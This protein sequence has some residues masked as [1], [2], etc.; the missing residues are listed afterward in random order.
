MTNAATL[1]EVFVRGDSNGYHI[2]VSPN[3]GYM[4]MPPDREQ[5]LLTPFTAFKRHWA[6]DDYFYTMFIPETNPDDDPVLSVLAKSL[7]SIEEVLPQ[8]QRSRPVYRLERHA[9]DDWQCLE[10]FLRR[11]ESCFA[12]W[13]GHLMPL[14][15]RHPR[16]PSSYGYANEFATRQAARKAVSM[17]RAAFIP[18]AALVSFHI[19]RLEDVIPARRAHAWDRGMPEDGF[20]TPAVVGLLRSS[21]MADFGRRRVGGFI[22]LTQPQP[23]WL[24]DL[25][26]VVKVAGGCV[27]LYYYLGRDPL[28]LPINSLASMLYDITRSRIE[29]MLAGEKRRC[30]EHAQRMES[31]RQQPAEESLRGWAAEALPAEQ[32]FFGWSSLPP[33]KPRIVIDPAAPEPRPGTRQLRGEDIF[34]FLMREQEHAQRCMAT[35][36]ASARRKRLQREEEEKARPYPTRRGPTVYHWLKVLGF[37]LRV[38]VPPSRCQAL[39]RDTLECHRIFNS[40]RNEWDVSERLCVPD[41]VDVDESYEGWDMKTPDLADDDDDELEDDDYGMIVDTSPVPGA[42]LSRTIAAVHGRARST[43]PRAHEASR[44][45]AAGRSE[46]SPERRA[47]DSIVA[48]ATA[49]VRR[50][51]DQDPGTDVSLQMDG[52]IEVLAARYGLQVSVSYVASLRD[53]DRLTKNYKNALRVL[54]QLSHD[55]TFDAPELPTILDFVD[56]MTLDNDSGEENAVRLLSDLT[57]ANARHNWLRHVS[58]LTVQRVT[59]SE[60]DKPCYVRYV[61]LPQ[62]SDRSW[63]L[64]VE[65]ATT[66]LEVVR[67]Q[68]GPSKEDAARELIKRE[69]P[70]R[71][72]TAAVLP[73]SSDVVAVTSPKHGSAGLGYR[74]P[75]YKPS[76]VDYMVYERQ[77]REILRRPHARVALSKGGIVWRLACEEVDP[78]RVLL[79]PQDSGPK[80]RE[81]LGGEAYED[82]AL[83]DEEIYTICGVYRVW[84]G[85]SI[86]NAPFHAHS[87]DSVP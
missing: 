83:S 27:P 44:S 16:L 25:D 48:L 29:A 72:L 52:L 17:A 33:P 50:D 36:S 4:S 39:W 57:P 56:S 49:L 8:G 11:L 77:R 74:E 53:K 45:T 7:S 1:P 61:L 19:M 46:S 54:F 67:R 68:W 71:T 31:G 6:N 5:P 13:G 79:G 9:A 18:W 43:S 42:V 41:G 35:E 23:R 3:D 47:E 82:D 28:A 58:T 60:G 2:Y 63:K 12:A 84:Q 30:L 37:W 86:L 76:T 78:G 20:M 14:G 70:F 65:D 69:I 75:N 32:V 85:A 64:V 15:F 55:I 73:S 62:G 24:D 34:G 40:F 10:T 80:V 21:W 87:T 38:Y 22:D 51:Y 59:N 66:A 81:D 26:Q